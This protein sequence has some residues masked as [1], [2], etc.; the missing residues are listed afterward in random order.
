MFD[1]DFAFNLSRHIMGL[2]L[3]S[4]AAFAAWRLGMLSP[5]GGV[6][7][8]L[9]GGLTYGL[10]GWPAAILLIVFFA[11]SSVLTKLFT[12][13]KREVNKN[14]AK[15]GRR[16]WAQ[17][18]ANGGA[19][20]LALLAGA[21]GWFSPAL[22]WAAYASAL[23]TVNADTW[24]TELGVLSRGQP[25]LITNGKRVPR[26]TSGAVSAQGSL[27]ALGGAALIAL[28]A[29]VLGDGQWG[30]ASL[31]ARA[32]SGLLGS[33]LDS[34]LGATVQ[35]IYYCP[36]CKKETERYPLHSCGTATQHRR[37][38][39]WLDNDWVN[40]ASAVFGALAALAATQF[41]L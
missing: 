2:F 10:G 41:W 11:S 32:G 36:Q 21:S 5:S 40:F 16:D 31:A 27:A 4:V 18:L 3:G 14:F 9:L 19:G 29:G 34:L 28:A 22:A 20:L 12:R 1:L 13:R 8:A 37:G 25:Q 35:A 23:A 26:G 33:Y 7:A 17:V 6:A 15:G 30:L 24:A 39:R 38:W